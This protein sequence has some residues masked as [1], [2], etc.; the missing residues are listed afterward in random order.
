M[1]V[2]VGV[3]G[4]GYSGRSF[5]SYLVDLAPG[6]RLYAISTRDPERQHAAQAEH[7]EA[8]VYGALDDLLA[9]RHVDLVVIATPHNTHRDLAMQAMEA[10]KHVVVDKVMCMNAQEAR[11]MIEASQRNGVMLSVFHNRRWDWDY[12]TVKKAIA[13]G[14]LGKPYL[15]Q[16]AITRYGPPRRWRASRE[17]SGGILFDWPAHFVDQALQLV[18]GQVESVYCQTVETA[19]WAIGIENYARLTMR[20]SGDVLYEIEVGNLATIG[21]PRWYVMGDQGGLIKYGLDPQEAALK[22]GHIEAAEEDPADRAQV[23][24]WVSGQERKIVVESVRASWMS[25][26]QNISDV[27]NRGAGLAVKPGEVLRVM[28][29]Y[30]AAMASVRTGDAVQVSI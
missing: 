22:Q 23:T 5:H 13:D 26:Y 24:T 3:I 10:G 27:L 19:R 17:E 1:T 16:A 11:E 30:D 7:P 14:Y 9:D 20:F 6:L 2:N 18:P 25:Y 15:F 29:V 8:K 12:L 21:K 4:Y 28:Q